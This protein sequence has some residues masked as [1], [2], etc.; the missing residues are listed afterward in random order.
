MTLKEKRLIGGTVLLTVTAAALRFI[1]LPLLQKHVTKVWDVLILAAVIIIA[2]KY[3]ES[4][5]KRIIRPGNVIA[6]AIW[7]LSF[8]YIL[9]CDYHLPAAVIVLLIMAGTAVW[10]YLFA[11][12]ANVLRRGCAAYRQRK[13]YSIDLSPAKAAAA[14]F[15]WT[16]AALCMYWSC[17]FPYRTSPDCR[18]QWKQIHGDISYCD[19][20]A[21]AHTIFLKALLSIYDSFTI[22]ILVQLLMI[23]ALFAMFAHF[24]TKKGVPFA[25]QF[26]VMGVFNSAAGN[27]EPYLFPWKDTPHTFFIGCLTLLICCLLDEPERFGL[28]KAV[29][30][31]ISLAGILL[32]RLNGIVT[33]IF[34][35][36]FLLAV[37]I[38]KKKYREM[39][40]SAVTFAVLFTANHWY[41]YDVLG[42]RTIPNG[43]G[44]QVFGTGIAA[45]V[46]DGRATDAELDEVSE[47]L[48]LDW[49]RYEY[50]PWELSSLIWHEDFDPRITADPDM[51]V[52]N[53]MLILGMG[54][55]KT[56]TIKLY[57][58]LLP[59]HF[60]AYAMNVV[61][62]TV[63]VWGHCHT[64]RTVFWF[65]N[66]SLVLLIC[67][68]LSANREKKFLRR[69]W[70][71]FLPVAGN[72]ISIA[73]ST[74][75]N[76]TRYLLSTFVLT[77][78]LILYILASEADKTADGHEETEQK[79]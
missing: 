34:A 24:L 43:F 37:L 78:F 6:A 57:L 55:H 10:T 69:R 8:T 13:G 2:V 65:D 20:H 67:M 53:N 46:N 23:A 29:F 5:R 70:A 61:N 49:L 71:I 56:G 1:D 11:G 36:I 16:F 12:I 59:R 41:A 35:V 47:F 30:T 27:T 63:I 26:A 66:I 52:L 17:Y 25:L 50:D 51:D 76:E 64:R 21:V 40:A 31:G 14:V 32:L 9:I 3:R 77:P 42:T 58:R 68:I 45:A 79:M 39:I 33:V 38:K 54:E 72:I 62:S 75:T 15:V 28:L 4:S 22:V 44:L 7:S 73:I 74:V 48:P 19:V 18:N 60:P